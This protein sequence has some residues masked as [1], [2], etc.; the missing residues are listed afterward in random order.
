MQEARKLAL[1][2]SQAVQT[3]KTTKKTPSQRMQVPMCVDTI[4]DPKYVPE[5]PFPL[6]SDEVVEV[7]D[8]EA[9][10][11]K[12]A[13]SRKGKAGAT[14][15]QKEAKLSE[16]KQTHSKKPKK[17]RKM[18]LVETKAK[19]G[20]QKKEVAH[21]VRKED[22]QASLIA[23]AREAE[24]LLHAPPALVRGS[25]HAHATSARRELGW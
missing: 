5:P 25:P 15:G 1:P 21:E 20:A 16:P 19:A 13:R 12:K 24:A 14:E 2:P 4:Y 17:S 9:P 6:I 3:K 8:W 22:L 10:L 7:L 11:E 23:E 18:P